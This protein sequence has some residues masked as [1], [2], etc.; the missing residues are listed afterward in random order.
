VKKKKLTR[1]ERAAENR[2]RLIHAAQEVVGEYGYAEASV[3]RIVERAGLAQGTF[4]LY[5]D[6]RQDLFDQLLPEVGG[7]ALAYIREAV[8]DA[9][10]FMDSEEKG[11]RAFFEYAVRNPAYFRV[12][13]E[14]EIAAPAAY[15]KYTQKRTGSF[16]DVVT[17][18]WKRGEIKGY[19]RQELGVLTQMMLA[20]RAYLFQ[21][22]AKT[23]SGIREPSSWVVD[24]Y[25]KFL[26]NGL[27]VVEPVRKKAGKSDR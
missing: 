1:A 8:K 25:V 19:T 5:F 11:L 26:T 7:K 22:F 4:Y 10:D 14:A 9:R 12:L 24:A 18:A 17:E 3:S 16:L 2:T 20:A 6:S 23:E 13:S 27:G 15:R 21:E